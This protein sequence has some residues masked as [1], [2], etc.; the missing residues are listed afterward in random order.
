MNT[1]TIVTE[2]ISKLPVSCVRVQTCFLISSHVQ[3][4]TALWHS[5]KTHNSCVVAP[6]TAVMIPNIQE[7]NAQF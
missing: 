5:I 2:K 6:V 3:A 7:M 1:I 4:G